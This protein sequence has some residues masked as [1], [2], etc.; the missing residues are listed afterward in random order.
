MI[1]NKL[2]TML[3]IFLPL[4][5]VGGVLSSCMAESLKDRLV[6]QEE[7]MERFIETLKANTEQPV[8]TVHYFNGVYRVVYE[9]GSGEP[10]AAGDMLEFY[11]WAINFNTK[12]VYDSSGTTVPERNRLG[13]GAY[14]PGLER[15]LTGMQGGEHAL[16]LLTGKEA[17]GNTGVGILPA[18]TPVMFEIFMLS[19]TK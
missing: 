9:S 13:A 5:G 2:Y 14:I 17:Y 3:C 11:Y 8:D 4:G 15:G 16:I 18:Y 19:I 6:K 10:A 12:A 1:R 7:D